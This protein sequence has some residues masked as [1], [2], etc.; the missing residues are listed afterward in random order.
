MKILFLPVLQIPTGHHAVADSLIRS[1]ESRVKNIECKKVD[2]FSYG[3]E[4]FEKRLRVAYLAWI[5]FL[6]KS[7]GYVYL[8]SMH[9]NKSKRKF[10]IVERVFLKKMKKLLKNE[11]PDLI[12]CTSSIPSYIVDSLRETGVKTA[13]VLNVY[14]DFWANNLW[15]LRNTEFH[16]VTDRNFKEELT[17]NQA[18]DPEKITVTGI[19]VDECFLEH[20]KKDPN[21]DKRQVLISGGSTGLGGIK[22][23]ISHLML[24]GSS[25]YSFVVLCGNNKNLYEKISD[26]K[27]DNVKPLAY[28]SSCDKMNE[29]YDSSHAIITKPGGVTVSEC[30]HKRLPIFICSSLPGQEEINKDYLGKKELVYDID[31][32]RSIIAQLDVFFEDLVE[33]E[34]WEVRVDEYLSE[35][36]S[37]AWKE[38]LKLTE[39][40]D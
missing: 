25:S 10:K 15:G 23:I 27:M 18:V 36:E 3:N 37:P 28:V 24:E 8:K 13:P 21:A 26:L 11:N 34:N 32:D 7:Y 35:I 17:K 22:K 9:S 40:I 31:L 16:Y 20:V 1:I 39:H 2:I 4:K 6:P 5:R 33:Q 29:I 12:V 14:T 38:L 19:P 30:L